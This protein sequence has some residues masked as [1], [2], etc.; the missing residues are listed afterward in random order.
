M[1]TGSR[2]RGGGGVGG[3]AAVVVWPA[4]VALSYGRGRTTIEHVTSGG[5]AVAVGIRK[6]E[7]GR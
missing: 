4:A 7:G 2:R 5:G 1:F 3:P 6:G